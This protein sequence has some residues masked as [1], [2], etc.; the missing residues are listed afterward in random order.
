ME[1]KNRKD[2]ELFIQAT[3][4]I[5]RLIMRN[6][7]LYEDIAKKKKIIIYKNKTIKT[8]N[9]TIKEKDDEIKKL[10]KKKK[11]KID[12]DFMIVKQQKIIGDNYKMIN[13]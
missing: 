4:L 13:K 10:K 1:D 8:K 12:K 3:E 6:E 7:H 11:M 5:K 2:N 9:E